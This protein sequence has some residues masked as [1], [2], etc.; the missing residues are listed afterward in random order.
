MALTGITD[1]INVTT[2]ITTLAGDVIGLFLTEPLIYF[3][4]LGF[5]GSV[6]GIVKRL[7]KRR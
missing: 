5:F 2:E 3:V 6:A 4:A 1:V 7:M